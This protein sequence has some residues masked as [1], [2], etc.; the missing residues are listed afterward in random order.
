MIE[1][2]E[3]LVEY[4]VNCDYRNPCIIM[5]DEINECPICKKKIKPIYVFG[6]ASRYVESKERLIINY[7]CNACK[8]N[9]IVQYSENQNQGF[10][11]IYF[12]KLDYISPNIFEKQ[13]FEGCIED[14]FKEFT[15]LYNQSLEAEHYNLKEIAGMGYRKSLEFLIK[16]FLIQEQLE[17]KEKIEKM[18]L[19]NCINQLINEPN[20]KK[21]AS[22]ATWLGNDQVHYKKLYTENDIEDL[23]N[24]IK[25]AT[26]WIEMIYLTKKYEDDI[27][28]K[29]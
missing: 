16:D 18:P 15:K 24:L 9:F 21:I 23:K 26:K 3:N 25:L 17:N 27:K 28:L 7:M 14:N 4:E 11:G 5:I 8:N 1:R 2:K 20:L 10:G 12:K 29:K 13:R 6:K 19:G 22:R